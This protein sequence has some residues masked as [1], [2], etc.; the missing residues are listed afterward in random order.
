MPSLK[1]RMHLSNNLRI[2]E[3]LSSRSRCRSFWTIKCGL[4]LL[5]QLPCFPTRD[6][7]KTKDQVMKEAISLGLSTVWPRLS[8]EGHLSKKTLYNRSLNWARE[9]FKKKWSLNRTW[10][11]R[12]L[13]LELKRAKRLKS[14]QAL[15]NSSTQTSLSCKAN[16]TKFRLT[17]WPPWKGFKWTNKCPF[18]SLR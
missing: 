3:I 12:S 18:S 9:L 4:I 8:P 1:F 11:S 13:L 17:T 5:I 10:C 6:C 7:L 16:W 2:R 14:T 15:R